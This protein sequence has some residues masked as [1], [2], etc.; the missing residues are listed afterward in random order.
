MT[1][2]LDQL[3]RLS[4]ALQELSAIADNP[5]LIRKG[6]FY[7]GWQ[8]RS[9]DSWEYR[10]LF[11]H[12]ESEVSLDKLIEALNEKREAIQNLANPQASDQRLGANKQIRNTY[13][14]N[15]KASKAVSKR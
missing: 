14:T 2:H 5:E 13:S 7:V 6:C 9:P 4:Q 12:E 8:L 3:S 10:N 1:R 15:G 11:T